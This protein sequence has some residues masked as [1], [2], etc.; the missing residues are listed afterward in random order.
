MRPGENSGI[1]KAVEVPKAAID[2]A[3]AAAF[4]N[5]I[6]EARRADME[7]ALQAALPFFTQQPVLLSDEDRE[8]LLR[9]ASTIEHSTI[10]QPAAGR[11]ADRLRNLAQQHYGVEGADRG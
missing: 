7:A 6:S 10:A 5:P 9:I 11:A 2:A 3:C 1:E 8:E 4:V